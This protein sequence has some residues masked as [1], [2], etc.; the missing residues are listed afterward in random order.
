MFLTIIKSA[1]RAGVI[2]LLALFHVHDMEKTLNKVEMGKSF[3]AFYGCPFRIYDQK[4]PTPVELLGNLK[5]SFLLNEI[6]IPLSWN[7]EGLEILVDDPKNLNKS[8]NIK[9]LMK[10]RKINFSVGIKEDIEEYIKRFFDSGKGSE[11]SA[12][13]SGDY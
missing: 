8:D 12:Q 11:E 9:T 6:W 10:T 1:S 4:I 7:K 5:K 2:A 3:S 13:E